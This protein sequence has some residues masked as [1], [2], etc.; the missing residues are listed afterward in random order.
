MNATDSL[1]LADAVIIDL[2]EIARGA[3]RNSY[4]LPY[5]DPLL[6]NR[7]R[8]AVLRRVREFL[9]KM[10]VDALKESL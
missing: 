8:A 6:Q 1:A 7:M 10:R 4:G 9:E 5:D 3:G 2:S